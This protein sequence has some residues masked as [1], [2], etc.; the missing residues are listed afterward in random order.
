[1]PPLPPCCGS[2]SCDFIIVCIQER[3]MMV[4]QSRYIA[5]AVKLDIDFD[6]LEAT[7]VLSAVK[8]VRYAASAHRFWL[9]FL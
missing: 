7:G 9:V 2:A 4:R 3:C 6:V 5:I 8:Q 1:M